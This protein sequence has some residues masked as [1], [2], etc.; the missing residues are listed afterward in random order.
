MVDAF[1][2]LILIS[3]MRRVRTESAG[4]GL[5]YSSINA[6]ISLSWLGEAFATRMVLLAGVAR[7]HQLA[8]LRQPAA[9]L[10]R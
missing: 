10:D 4:T 6:S 5:S 9:D 8:A 3:A 1:E 7:D 2:Y